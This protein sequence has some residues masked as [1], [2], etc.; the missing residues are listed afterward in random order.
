M[1]GF[2][3]GDERREV[4]TRGRIV[5][6]LG[7][8]GASAPQ[9]AALLPRAKLSNQAVV[10]R[11]LRNGVF[12]EGRPGHDRLEESALDKQRVGEMTKM[13][14]VLIAGAILTAVSVFALLR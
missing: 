1:H 9:S 10:A 4:R 11:H 13:N 14:R 5:D 3:R 6:H 12:I 8:R 7:A 2:G